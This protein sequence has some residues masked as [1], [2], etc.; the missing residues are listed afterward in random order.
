ML[1][2]NY[3]DEWFN[4][5]LFHIR[6]HEP[7]LMVLIVFRFLTQLYKASPVTHFGFNPKPAPQSTCLENSR[8][9]SQQFPL[10]TSL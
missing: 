9:W 2:L 4:N 6:Q 10:S 5:R 1:P 8:S 7:H 3:G